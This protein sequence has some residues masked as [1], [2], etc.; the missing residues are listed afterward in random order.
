M[1]LI[2]YIL[3]LLIINCTLLITNCFSQQWRVFTTSNSPLPSNNISGLIV[4]KNNIKWI[5]TPKGMVK[6][7]GNIWQI[8]DSLNTPLGTSGIFP[9]ALDSMNNIWC[10]LTVKGIAKFDGIN[11]TMYNSTNSGLPSNSV[12]TISIDNYSTKWIGSGG[13][14]KFNDINWIV[15]NTTNSGLPSN[16]V[17]SIAVENHIKWIGTF[18]I[19]GGMAKF[20]DTS[21]VIYNTSNSQIPSNSINDIKI[22]YLGNKWICTYGG[23]VAKFNSLSNSWTKYDP[24]NSG[25]PNYYP[26]CIAFN[27]NYTKVIGTEGSG[28]ALF[29]DTIWQVFNTSN[30]PLPNN[31]II[32]ITVDMQGN[33]WIGTLN[34]LAVYNS[35]NIIG[36][37]NEF[38]I[39]PKKFLLK[40]NIPNPFNPKT[41]IQYSLKSNSNVL[42]VVYDIN[43]KSV[44]TL[45]NKNQTAANYKIQFDG[46]N[47]SSG[48]YF[49]KLILG[50]FSET[51]KM[52]LLK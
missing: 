43:G 19:S 44:T 48:I 17:S 25:L 4:D 16:V 34:G 7:N 40:Q 50:K 38:E 41:E 10:I 32:R 29:N 33:T 18:A 6:I 12:T 27:K 47:L 13:L 36:V 26:Y 21:W 42:L 15:Y 14:T 5:G 28:I 20:N 30:S 51:K 35:T 49:Y 22:D 37:N 8:F 24:S 23:G 45:V 39:L 9:T 11:W 2:K 1:K 52:V 31:T 46:S 3:T